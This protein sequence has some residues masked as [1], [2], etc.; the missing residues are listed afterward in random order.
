MF[1]S[2]EIMR[3]ALKAQPIV[4]QPRAEDRPRIYPKGRRCSCG[5][6]L[7]QFNGS[8]ACN[9]CHFERDK[10]LFIGNVSLREIME[11]EG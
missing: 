5:N 8:H 4:T 9:A 3:A 6:L 7:S 1:S 2:L 11:G 10:L